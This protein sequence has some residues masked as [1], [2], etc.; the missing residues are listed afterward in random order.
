[1]IEL[2]VLNTKNGLE[3]IYPSD[4]NEKKKLKLDKVYKVTIKQDRNYQFHKKF[5]ALCKLGCENS[6]NVEMPLNIYRKYVTMKAG[7]FDVYKTPKGQLVEAKSISFGNMSQKDFESLYSRV[8]DVIIQD[9]GATREFI[10]NELL[11]F[12]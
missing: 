11:S 8:L 7:Y 3:P 12:M 4:F 2:N 5:F 9:T 1:M 6:K 10:E